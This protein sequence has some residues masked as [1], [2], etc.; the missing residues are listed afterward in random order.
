MHSPDEAVPARM[1]TCKVFPYPHSRV[2]SFGHCWAHA[3]PCIRSQT[4]KSQNHA[5]AFALSPWP[6]A[7]SSYLPETTPA[8]IKPCS[9]RLQLAR[10]AFPLERAQ[11]RQTISPKVSSF[12]ACI[13]RLI[14]RL[15]LLLSFLVNKSEGA[16]TWLSPA[17]GMTHRHQVCRRV[18]GRWSQSSSTRSVPS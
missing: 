18:I 1:S 7:L 8:L 11:R 5:L 14:H 10:H 17:S 3:V 15:F 2:R 16:G 9:H 4:I 12:L 6:L 13:S